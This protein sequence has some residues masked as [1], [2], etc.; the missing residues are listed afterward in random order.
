MEKRKVK[1][2]E[3]ENK[4]I[5]NESYKLFYFRIIFEMCLN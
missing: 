1:N 2:Y 4:I 5:D 3:L